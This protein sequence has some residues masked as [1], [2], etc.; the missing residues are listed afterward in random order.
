VV[1]LG[2]DGKSGPS[3]NVERYA[4]ILTT[5]ALQQVPWP[6]RSLP[7]VNSNYAAGIYAV[8][9]NSAC[10]DR[11][12]IRIGQ[13]VVRSFEGPTQLCAPPYYVNST[14]NP[15][16]YLYRNPT[17][18]RPVLPCVLYRTQVPNAVFPTVSGDIVQVAPMMEKIAYS[19][20]DQ[21]PFGP[22]AFI[23]DPFIA[24]ISDELGGGLFEPLVPP[25]PGQHGIYLLDT[26]P[27]IRKAAY[28]YFLLR[29]GVDGEI[30]QVV[31]TNVIDLN[32]TP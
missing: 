22:I 5:P 16:D 17:N 8:R 28:R 4:W 9:L 11:I 31:P 13:T 24:V 32:L 23:N 30:E 26:T 7:A 14:N 19:K 1:A 12:G 18:D 15:L 21:S 6:A 29:F 20:F 25:M 10:M 2:V 27:L 3:S